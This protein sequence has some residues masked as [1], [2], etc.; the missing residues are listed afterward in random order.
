M[1]EDMTKFIELNRRFYKAPDK[2]NP[3]ESAQD[4]Y[5]LSRLGSEASLSWSEL[6]QHRLVVILGEPG[7]GKSTEFRLQ[8]D[9]LHRQSEQAFLLRLDRLVYEPFT[10]VLSECDRKD[11]QKWKRGRHF[12]YFFFDSVDESKLR[13]SDD[14]LTALDKIRDAINIQDLR[15]ASLIFS[16]RISEWRRV[17]D[18]HEINIRFPLPYSNHENKDQNSKLLV[19]HLAPLDQSR[20]RL[21]AQGRGVAAPDDFIQALNEHYAWE[22]ARRPLDVNA[23]VEYWQ[24][25]GRLGSLTELI[26]HNLTRSLRE[27]ETRETAC[28]LTLEKAR[29]GAE[30]LAAAAM[31]CK[32]LNFKVPDDAFIP[33]SAAIDASICLPADWSAAERRSLL[34]RPLFDGATYGCIRFHHR[35]TLEYLAASWLNERMK[36]GCPIDRLDDL[37]FDR[38]QGEFILR[39]ALAPV[40]AWL[41][42]GNAPHNR[43]VRERL[44]QAAPGVHFIYGDPAQLPLDYKRKIL[45]ALTTRYKD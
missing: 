40:A 18:E 19:V 42:S 32:N 21:Y 34:D 28:H 5:L 12:A 30:A 17:T 31:L 1:P 14:F 20:V 44:L 11:F 25:Y 13:K 23:M 38:R 26:E 7:S 29:K 6:L 16:S 37:L 15:R 4:S 9:K 41:A 35:R 8:L 22:F 33:A 43:L 10:E 45:Q 24:D 39:L 27:S 36:D 3:E 2:D